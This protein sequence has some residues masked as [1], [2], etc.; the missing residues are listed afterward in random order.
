MLSGPVAV[1]V[2]FFLPRPKS[3]FGTGRNATKLK[4]CAPD[5]H[6]KKP[7]VDKLVRAVLDS[8]SGVVYSDDCQVVDLTTSKRFE[9]KDSG[10][11]I[12]V[13]Q[14]SDSMHSES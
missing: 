2:R 6:V 11:L 1:D 8:L 3:H 10:V 9:V 13:G 14:L 5:F 12:S 4:D 7:D